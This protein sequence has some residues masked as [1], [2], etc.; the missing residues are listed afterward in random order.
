STDDGE[1]QRSIPHLIIAWSR[2]EPHRIGEAAPIAQPCVLGRGGPQAQDPAPRVVFLQQRPTGVVAM[3]PLAGS[4]IS[5]LQLHFTPL[6]GGL[7]SVRSVGRS[8]LLVNGEVTSSAVVR[9]C[10]TVAL[11]NA[12][13]LL[14]TSRRK[15]SLALRSY[16]QEL[17]SFPFGGADVH[18]IVG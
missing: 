17:S 15:S 5:R 11:R 2:E 6:A 14:V 12:L 3:P 10:D 8:T 7:V 18:G 13:V 1:P 9:A 4:R 16:P